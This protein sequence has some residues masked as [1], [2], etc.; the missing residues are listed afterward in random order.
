M[1]ILAKMAERKVDQYDNQLAHS[2]SCTYYI[3][4][5]GWVDG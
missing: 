5:R 1:V 3:T 2:G 4:P